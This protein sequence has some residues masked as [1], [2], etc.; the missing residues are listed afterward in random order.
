MASKLSPSMTGFWDF[1]ASVPRLKVLI[2]RRVRGLTLRAIRWALALPEKR[3][4]IPPW[5]S[6]SSWDL[7]S[8]FSWRTFWRSSVR[9][10]GGF[11]WETP[12]ELILLEGLLFFGMG[13]NF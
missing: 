6:S 1:W 2:S 13:I 8:L 5:V 4:L 9:F 11:S 12:E 3:I 10:W 7:R